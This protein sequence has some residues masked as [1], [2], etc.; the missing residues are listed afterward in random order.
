MR[1]LREQRRAGD[2]RSRR[3]KNSLIRTCHGPEGF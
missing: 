1:A 3:E 2:L